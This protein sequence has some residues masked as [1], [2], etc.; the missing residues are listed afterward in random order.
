MHGLA[1]LRGL[2][3]SL[4]LY[5]GS[6]WRL[7]AMERF[8]APF[9]RPGDLCFDIGAH[10]GNRSLVWR[11]L[12][13]RVIALEPQPDYAAFLRWLFRG[14]GDVQILEA[15][16]A[17]RPGEIELRISHRHATV[18]TASEQFLA[19]T[20]D[21]AGFRDV[22]WSGAHTVEA[23]TLDD[24]IRRH[25]KPAFV[26]LDVEGYEAEALA[27]LGQ[28]IPALSF[29]YL[30]ETLAIAETCV[31]RL[32]RLGRYTYNASPGESM[33]FALPAWVGPE[34][35]RAWLRARPPGSGSGDVYARLVS[36]EDGA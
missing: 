23:V 22:A 26:K 4:W 18:T 14:S 31:D 16:I 15:G 21:S 11:R 20:A 32:E 24:L 27:G 19:M 17:A 12:G 6:P 28:P 1:R 13:A 35:M 25:G 9:I 3:R 29:E 2:V 30:A 34:D 10:V 33:A 36:P 8:Y 7:R 5:Y